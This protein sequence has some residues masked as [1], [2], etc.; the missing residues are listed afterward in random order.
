[1]TPTSTARHIIYEGQGFQEITLEQAVELI[2]DKKIY[3][4]DVPTKEHR[5]PEFFEIDPVDSIYHLN[6]GV[7]FVNLWREFDASD[8]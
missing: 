1:M 8:N 7:K 4:C 6:P 2:I 5:R 3:R